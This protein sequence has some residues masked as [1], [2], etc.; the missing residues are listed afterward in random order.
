[1]SIS[2]NSRINWS[3]INNIYTSLNQ[4]RTKWGFTTTSPSGAQN[5][6]VYAND[7]IELKNKI[8][9]MSSNA[10]LANVAKVD[11]AM[12]SQGEIILPYQMT[13]MEDTI[14]NVLNTCAFDA[15]FRSGFRS[16]FRGSFDG[17]FRGSFRG[18]HRDGFNSFQSGHGNSSNFSFGFRSGNQSFSFNAG[19]RGVYS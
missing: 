13:S 11:V 9:E 14:Y 12:P 5:R 19:G 7:A 15:A 2:R 18:S 10:Y 17:G 16:G 1:M 8:E 3:D 4:A 6:D